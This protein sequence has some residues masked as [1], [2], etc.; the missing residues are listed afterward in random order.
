VKATAE[1]TTA[2]TGSK[3]AQKISGKSRDF[4]N[5]MVAK[6]AGNGLITGTFATAG[7]PTAAGTIAREETHETSETLATERASSV[8]KNES[9]RRDSI[10]S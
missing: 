6:T 3:V 4:N 8:A 1:R 2:T 9:N 10:Y 5:S 7:T